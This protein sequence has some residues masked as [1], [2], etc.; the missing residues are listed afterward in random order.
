MTPMFSSCSNGLMEIL[1]Y[2]I[3]K[4]GPVADL[5]E[6]TVHLKLYNWTSWIGVRVDECDLEINIWENINKEEWNEEIISWKEKRPRK[7]IWQLLMYEDEPIKR[8]KRSL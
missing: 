7:E 3:G 1:F 2:A 8:L 6:E 5:K 4:C